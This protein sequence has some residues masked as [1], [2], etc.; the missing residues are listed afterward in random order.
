MIIRHINEICYIREHI[1]Y[2]MGKIENVVH[3]YW[4]FRVRLVYG[5]AQHVTGIRIIFALEKA[6]SNAGSI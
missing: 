2:I 1:G 5:I 3:N 6:Y 4:G